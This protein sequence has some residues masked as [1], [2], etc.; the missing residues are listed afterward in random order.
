VVLIIAGVGY[1]GTR[2]A[3][4]F[5]ANPQAIYM[6]SKSLPKNWENKNVEVVLHTT[7]KNQVPGAPEVVAAYAW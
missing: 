4:D 2:A 5:I 6:L 7:V 3:G 1:S